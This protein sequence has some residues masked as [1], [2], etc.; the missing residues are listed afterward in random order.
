VKRAILAALLPL[1]CTRSPPGGPTG[2]GAAVTTSL[3][4]A[5]EAAPGGP[6]SAP[7]AQLAGEDERL[8][9]PACSGC[10]VGQIVDHDG[11]PQKDAI[12]YVKTG[13]RPT[14]PG[15]PRQQAVVDQR[16]KAFAPH[17][18]AIQAGTKVLFNNSDIVLHNVYSRS[19]EKTQDLGAFG[20][21]QSRQMTL[22][23]PG[24]VDIFCAIH[25]NMHAIILVVDTPFFAT[26]DAH[27]YFE[28]RNM[29][30][31]PYGLRIWTEHHQEIDAR[32]DVGG[33]PAVV[34]ARL[35]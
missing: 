6:G 22:E 30:P 12:V 10:V 18:L 19:P 17:V 27:G 16:D 29:P 9:A 8:L 25:T 23:D 32:A 2:A 1:A 26:T 14:K 11:R 4:L 7:M 34:R 20:H 15:A 28:L 21:G 31:G 33:R 24:R 35:P 3:A 5:Q 13:P